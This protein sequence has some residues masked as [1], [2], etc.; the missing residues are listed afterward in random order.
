VGDRLAFPDADALAEAAADELVTLASAAMTRA[1]RCTVVLAGGSTPLRLYRLLARPP[2]RNRVDWDRVEWFWGDERSVPPDHPDSNYG[3]ARQ[4]LL[5]PLG[6]SDARVHRMEAERRDRGAAACAYAADIAR[7]TG[8]D[9]AGDPPALDL[10]LLG[11][12]SDGHTAS[13]FPGSPALWELRRWV[14]TQF[15]PAL[16]TDRITLTPP[17]LNRARE[18]RI[19]VAGADKAAALRAVEA[20]PDQPE[21][22]PVQLIRPVEGR[23]VWLVD[24]AA[25]GQT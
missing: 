9:P 6:V 2:H 5:G 3:A 15:V 19:L 11:M 7:V 25:A 4:A 20:E 8:V 22:Y 10:V 23:L 13:L 21:R 16:G 1:G 18:I 24:A 12:G 17:I 14:V